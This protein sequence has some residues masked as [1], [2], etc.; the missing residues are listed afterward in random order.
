ME[1]VCALWAELASETFGVAPERFFDFLLPT[2][3][4]AVSS[5]PLSKLWF[6]KERPAQFLVLTTFAAYSQSSISQSQIDCCALFSPSAVSS[7]PSEF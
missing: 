2:E 4:C 5:L 6:W 1:S 3:L 7:A